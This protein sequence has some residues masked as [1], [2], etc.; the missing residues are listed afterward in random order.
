MPIRCPAN[1]LK[2]FLGKAAKQIIGNKLFILELYCMGV[3]TIWLNSSNY[4]HITQ[5]FVFS[6]SILFDNM[7]IDYSTRYSEPKQIIIM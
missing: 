5:L 3:S 7:Q 4:W 1:S 2:S 6:R